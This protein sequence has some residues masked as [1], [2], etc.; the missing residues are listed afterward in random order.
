MWPREH[1][2]LRDVVAVSRAVNESSFSKMIFDF[3]SL[4][5]V[6]CDEDVVDYLSNRLV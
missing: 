5:D 4:G 2:T 3:D 6:E 1:S